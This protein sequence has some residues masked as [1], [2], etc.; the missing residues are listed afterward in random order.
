MTQLLSLTNVS[1]SFF[2]IK[3]EIK[4]LDNITFS[5]ENNQIIAL[6]GPSGCGKSTILNIISSLEKPT[7]GEIKIN[8]K[9]GY[10]FQKDALLPW[11]SVYKN[12][13][14]GLE[15]NKI[16]TIENK[17]YVDE[18]IH[19]YHL[20]EFKNSFPN[21]ISGGMRQRVALIRTLVLKPDL[22][23]LDEPF[24]ALDAQTKIEVQ[25]DVYN[26]IKQE[27]KSALIV[28]HDIS[29]AIALAD[30]IIILSERPAK[31]I[32]T[33]EIAIN[34]L[35]PNERRKDVRF[36]NYYDLITKEIKKG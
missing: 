12:I 23:L 36:I 10:M 16:L 14:I 28:T 18:L 15:I 9:L 4:V 35:E 5:I 6:L 33:I 3:K 19:K 8:T 20:L 1:K 27:K 13:C 17:K 22:L 34:N 21:Q 32:K 29:E 30:K 2:D 11:R 24:S 7:N 25:N 26:I 31:I